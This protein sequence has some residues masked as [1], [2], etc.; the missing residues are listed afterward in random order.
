MSLFSIEKAAPAL[1]GFYFQHA[2]LGHQARSHFPRGIR[3]SAHA[4][5]RLLTRGPKTCS[6]VTLFTMSRCGATRSLVLC[7]EHTP[8]I[9]LLGVCSLH[10]TS[11][12]KAPKLDRRG[13]EYSKVHICLDNFRRLTYIVSSR[14]KLT[15]KPQIL[16]SASVSSFWMDWSLLRTQS[17]QK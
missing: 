14:D 15:G 12:Q 4:S 9:F 7:K 11:N 10:R 13:M 5:R 6:L 2:L 8:K 1:H 16:Y 17:Y 3:L